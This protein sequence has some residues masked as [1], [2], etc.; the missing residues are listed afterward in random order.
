MIDLITPNDFRGDPYGRLTNQCAHIILGLGPAWLALMVSPAL[1]VALLVAF[2]LFE[3]WQWRRMGGTLAD[4]AA[5]LFFFA[6]G[7]SF[8]FVCAP[9]A[10][11][12][13]SI[14][15]IAVGVVLVAHTRSAAR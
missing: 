2:A 7:W 1:A 14:I 13:S 11:W 6:G 10:P 9:G 15:I 4:S 3:L 8:A 5:D 12:H